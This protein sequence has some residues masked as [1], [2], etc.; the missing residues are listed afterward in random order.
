MPGGKIVQNPFGKVLN[1]LD[2]FLDQG[3]GALRKY[4][5]VIIEY[6]KY[7]TGRR[8]AGHDLFPHAPGKSAVLEHKE[9]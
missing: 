1:V 4:T 8:G 9:V 6:F 2:F 3:I 5:T 7:R